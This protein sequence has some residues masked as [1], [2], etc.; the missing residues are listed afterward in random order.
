MLHER[1]PCFREVIMLQILEVKLF[2]HLAPSIAWKARGISP[3]LWGR[4]ECRVQQRAS[5]N[6]RVFWGTGWSGDFE[7]EVESLP[8]TEKQS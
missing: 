3:H 6:P 7:P 4:Q 8:A 5:F 1:V 2:L